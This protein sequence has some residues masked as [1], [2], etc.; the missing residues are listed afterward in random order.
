[1]TQKNTVETLNIVPAIVF[2]NYNCIYI[3][4]KLLNLRF[5]NETQLIKKIWNLRTLERVESAEEKNL[6]GA[7]IT[8]LE[9]S[10]LQKHAKK[11]FS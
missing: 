5:Y 4:N 7:E 8:L 2:Y 6:F 10:N 1:M 11:L 3:N 9:R